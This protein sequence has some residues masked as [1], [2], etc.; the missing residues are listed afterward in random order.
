MRR[1]GI[2]AGAGLATFVYE[3]RL[4]LYRGLG[5]AEADA[6][7]RAFTDAFLVASAIAA[8]AAGLS[9]IPPAVRRDRLGASRGR[10]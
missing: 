2:V 9:L 3:G 7:A 1:G 10:I 5:A 8:T 6:T 4:A